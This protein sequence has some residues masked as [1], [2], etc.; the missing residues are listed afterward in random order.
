M[1]D[2]YRTS[3]KPPVDF[4]TS[5]T[6]NNEPLRLDVA[7]VANLDAIGAILGVPRGTHR[8]L[9]TSDHRYRVA[10]EDALEGQGL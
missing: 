7:T 2:P 8:G 9:P 10:L 4:S 6:L 1:S 5:F 3:A